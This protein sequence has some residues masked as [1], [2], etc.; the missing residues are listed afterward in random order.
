M[1][2]CPSCWVGQGTLTGSCCSLSAQAV[3]S[4]VG[5]GLADSETGAAAAELTLVNQM[6]CRPLYQGALGNCGKLGG[7]LCHLLPGAQS[8]GTG[9]S[10]RFHGLAVASP[11]SRG[12]SLGCC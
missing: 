3:L 12:V 9:A 7:R 11:C 4:P 8:C 10:C 1:H 5:P 6:A 2:L